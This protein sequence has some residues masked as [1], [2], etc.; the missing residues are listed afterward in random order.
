MGMMNI[1][2]LGSNGQ[3]GQEFKH[4]AS[5]IRDIHFD[6]FDRGQLDILDKDRLDQVFLKN[7]YDYVINCAAYTAVDKAESDKDLC[8][9]INTEACENL[10]QCLL[11]TKSKLVHFSSDYVY[12]S[13][14]NSP[15][16]EDDIKSPRGVYAKSKLEGENAIRR[17]GIPC[18]ILRTSW[19]ISSYGHNFVKTILRLAHE[20]PLLQV[21]DDQ[22]GAPTYARDLAS[23]VIDIVLQVHH[24]PELLPAFND[25][26][27]Y[28]SI[29]HVSWFDIARYIVKY[30]S[31]D[32]EVHP[33]PSK[34]YP[35]P[36]VRPPWSV[37]S[38]H[39]IQAQFGL[40]IKK[41]DEALVDCL[42]AI[43]Q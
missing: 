37:L 13:V 23:A 29:G 21:V 41:W 35:T 31:L 12:H 43:K 14:T 8:Y 36:A 39:K 24:R 40:N 42:V 5:N 27:N 9:A 20:R 16:D 10:A 30:T 18:L 6:F 1:A 11:N 26:Y 28:S 15:I 38:K 2:V 32:C 17:S 22:I 7:T 4:L 34:D 33:I 19:V 3:L 25:T